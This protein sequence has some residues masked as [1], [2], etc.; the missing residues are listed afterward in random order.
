MQFIL[1][2][3][4]ETRKPKADKEWK[5]IFQLNGFFTAISMNA[6]QSHFSFLYD[7]A[8]DFYW[9]VNTF[10]ASLIFFLFF[11]ACYLIWHCTFY[12]VPRSLFGSCNFFFALINLLLFLAINVHMLHKFRDSISLFLVN[13]VKF[14]CTLCM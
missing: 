7:D 12:T 2:F 4:G 9:T 1:V 3:E 10:L 11:F 6:M 13:D 8:D 5:F 14:Q